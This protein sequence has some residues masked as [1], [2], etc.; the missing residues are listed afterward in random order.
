MSVGTLSCLDNPTVFIGC[1]T[2]KLKK[3]TPKTQHHH[4]HVPV[5]NPHNQPSPALNGFITAF[6]SAG[7]QPA[8][9]RPHIQDHK[10]QWPTSAILNCLLLNDI[11]TARNTLGTSTSRIP[12][13]ASETL[14]R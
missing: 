14:G 3:H 11:A 9:L 10:S 5:V 12:H 13:A 8:S 7:S 1:G 2:L 6:D 4:L